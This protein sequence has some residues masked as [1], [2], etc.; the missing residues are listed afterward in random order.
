MLEAN[1]NRWIENAFEI[2]NKNLLRRR[3]NSLRVNNLE[4]LSDNK[5]SIIYANHSSWWDGLVAFQIS[6]S[7]K[8]DS[9]IM[10]EEKQLRNLFFF[11]KLGAFSVVRE[12]PREAVKS[13]KYAI[14]LLEEN[15]NRTLW[16]FPQGKILPNDIRPIK[17]YNGLARII[18]KTK[19]CVVS[20]LAIRYEFL[21][22]YKPD[23]FIKIGQT[24]IFGARDVSNSKELTAK[25]EKNLTELLD[26]LKSDFCSN[27]LK[28][29]KNII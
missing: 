13:L 29:Y 12:N 23:V 20:S 4:L 5:P 11:R 14:N 10:M 7:I 15:K 3:F 9:F 17:F 25:L 28:H 22:A 24:E 8:A 6:R 19:S 27:N 18:E 1:K 2:Y 21:G 16:I 26:E